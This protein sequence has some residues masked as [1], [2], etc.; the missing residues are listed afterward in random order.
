MKNKYIAMVCIIAASCLGGYARVSGQTAGI[1][2]RMVDIQTRIDAQQDVILELQQRLGDMER[3]K[4]LLLEEIEQEVAYIS[5]LKR[6]NER[7]RRGKKA[8]STGAAR[9]TPS[10]DP[11]DAELKTEIDRLQEMKNGLT[12]ERNTLGHAVK[13]YP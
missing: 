8:L 3:E 2:T 4:S 11:V 12:R 13:Q 7:A 6:V 9:N 5:D 10:A 1:N